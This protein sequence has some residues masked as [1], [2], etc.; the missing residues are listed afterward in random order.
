LW[1][2]GGSYSLDF[3][4]GTAQRKHVARAPPGVIGGMKGKE[5]EKKS[6]FGCPKTGDDPFL[7]ADD[8]NWDNAGLKEEESSRCEQGRVMEVKKSE[9][10]DKSEKELVRRKGIGVD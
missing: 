2:Y 10:S 4:V 6:V 7:F 3:T 5:R 9:K 8:G 1:I